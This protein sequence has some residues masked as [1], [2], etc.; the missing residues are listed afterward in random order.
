MNRK[1]KRL[2]LLGVAV[3]AVSLAALAIPGASAIS[4][5]AGWAP[6]MVVNTPLPVALQGTGNIAGNVN[7]AQSGSW[8]VGVT[9]LP[10]VQ[11][12]A[13]TTVGING[14]VSIADPAK[15]AFALSLCST[16]SDSCGAIPEAAT[17]PVG[18][19]Y[20]IEQAS[21]YCV[22]RDTGIHG[23]KLRASLNGQIYEHY[24]ADKISA[25]DGANT[26]GLFMEK[27]QIYVDGGVP[28]GLSV[29]PVPQDFNETH[30]EDYCHITLSGHV[31]QMPAQFP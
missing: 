25:H 31:V 23:W 6:V 16:F 24:V 18:T 8:S 28:N 5:A 20:V 29:Q 22:V 11:L 2:G 14:G 9:S 7:A 19:R 1:V 15:Q 10:A 21:G 4:S 3:A 17:L 26:T 12:A 30:P 27:T 13:G